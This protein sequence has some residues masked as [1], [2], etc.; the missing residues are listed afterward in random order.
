LLLWCQRRTAE[1]HA[2]FFIKDFSTSWTSGLALCGLIH[3]HRPDLIDYPSLNKSAARHNTR[4][5][6]D[7]A[8]QF[9]G[10]PKLM[11]AE[12]LVDVARPEERKSNQNFLS[13]VL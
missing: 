9:L 7:V 10:V 12:D 13:F 4:L 11:D 2:D 6:M 8:E 1:Y 5:A 3:H